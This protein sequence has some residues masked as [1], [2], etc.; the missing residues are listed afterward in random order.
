MTELDTGYDE[1]LYE[2]SSLSEEKIWTCRDKTVQP[3]GRITEVPHNQNREQSRGHSSDPKQRSGV[4]W[5]LG[6]IF[7]PSEWYTDTDTDHSTGVG[8]SWSL[9]YIL[10]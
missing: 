8:T 5:L 1:L 7:K 2:N 4:H 3:K 9:Y 10:W 6:Y